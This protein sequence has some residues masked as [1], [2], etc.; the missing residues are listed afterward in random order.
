MGFSVTAVENGHAAL[1]AMA[2]ERY[3]LV[4]TDFHMPKMDGVALTR[5]IRD[6]EASDGG[7]HL[8]ILGLTADVTGDS[9]EICLAA[10][11]DGVAAKPTDMKGLGAALQNLLRSQFEDCDAGAAAPGPRAVFDDSTYREIFAVGD[12]EGKQWLNEFMRTAQTTLTEL[13]AAA[14]AADHLELAATAHKLASASLV[15]GAMQLGDCGRSIEGL[16]ANTDKE[17]RLAAVSA[18]ET[19]YAAARIEIMRRIAQSDEVAS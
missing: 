11:M 19:A 14:E 10:G 9:R 3:D 8:P 5:A 13:R 18:A 12:L 17:E 15:A 2:A 16:A 1:A 6:S 7:M 4:I